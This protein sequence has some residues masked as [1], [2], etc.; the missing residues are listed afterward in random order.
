MVTTSQG[1]V[2]GTSIA[3]T[4]GIQLSGFIVAYALQ[5]ETFYDILGGVN[6]LALALWSALIPGP[7]SWADDPHKV[8]MTVLFLC[9]RSWL[10]LFLA[11]RAHERGGDSRFDEIKTNFVKFL[12]AWLVQ[13][14]WC[15]LISVP[16][17]FVN[18]SSVYSTFFTPLDWISSVGFGLGIVCEL[19]ADVQKAIWVKKGREGGFCTKGIWNYSRH[20]NYFGEMLQW[21]C[22]WLLA[23]SSSEKAEG[24]YSDPLWW[25][26]IVSP[27][28]TM[29]ILMN[30]PSTGLAHAEGQNLKRY[31][32][33]N[34]E[35]YSE[36]RA[37][38]SILMPM[39]GYRYVPMFLKRTMFLDFPWYEYRPSNNTDDKNKED[40][41]E[42]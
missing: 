36:Y 16:M 1:F 15:F 11:W 12:V 6:Y 28:F 9:S 24:G 41:T 14:A 7:S 18:S 40:Y 34:A 26:C 13:G 21:W 10:L 27:L 35:K 38:T 31:Y 3:I 4:L 17:I 8:A 23:Y 20:P 30:V 29:H 22:S 33:D 37:S 2:Y 32:D 39:I 25:F 42:L 19:V 5:T